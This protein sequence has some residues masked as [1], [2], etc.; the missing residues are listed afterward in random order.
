MLFNF[1]GTDAKA[2]RLDHRVHSPK[3]VEV[4]FLV[5]LHEVA[6]KDNRFAREAINLSEP[7]RRSFGRVPISLGYAATAVDKL[8]RNTRR[9]ILSL[10]IQDVELNLGNRLAD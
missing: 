7:F 1:R 8:A 5:S 6:R 9:A 3:E 4:T 2:V 10:V